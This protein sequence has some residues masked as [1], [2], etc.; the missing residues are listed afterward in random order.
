[1]ATYNGSKYIKEQLDSILNQKEVDVSLLIADDKSTDDTFS[2]LQEYSEK[3]SNITV[4]CNPENLGYRLNFFSMIKRR[5]CDRYDFFALSDQDDVWEADKLINA[6]NYIKEHAGNLNKPLLYSSNLL[7]VD[8]GLAPIGCMNTEGEIRRFNN[9]NF[10]LENKC[11]GCTAV[12]NNALRERLLL[13]P[14]EMLCCPHDDLM[15]KI[16]ITFGEYLFDERSF[17]KYRQHSNNQIGLNNRG[18]LKKYVK[19]FFSD[20]SDMHSKSIA[21]ILKCYSDAGESAYFEYLKVIADYKNSFKSWLRFLFSAKYKKTTFIK[22]L[23]L[24]FAVL[25]K[26]Y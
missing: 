13:F 5:L 21:N 2:I 22:T 25:F 18:K 6:V 14:D 16:A 24:K 9:Y 26:K 8:E 10:L 17:I 4:Y 1:M 19:M 12:F 11:T 15:S 3:F 23:I 20:D 7:A